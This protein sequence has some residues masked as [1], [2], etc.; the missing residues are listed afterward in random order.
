MAPG[1]SLVAARLQPTLLLEQWQ[2]AQAP[3]GVLR[4]DGLEDV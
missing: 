4:I 1:A 3:F 2:D